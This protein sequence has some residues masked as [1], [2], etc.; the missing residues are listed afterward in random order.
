ML[1]LLSIYAFF[2]ITLITVAQGY[3]DERLDSSSEMMGGRE[4]SIFHFFL[5][6]LTDKCQRVSKKVDIRE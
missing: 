2:L 5:S 6:S 1:V 3:P 4:M